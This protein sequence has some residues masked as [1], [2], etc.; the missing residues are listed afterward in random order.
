M[1]ISIQTLVPRAVAL[2]AIGYCAWPSV[3]ALMEEPENKPVVQ[4]P[5]LDGSLLKPKMPPRPVRNPFAVKLPDL[6]PSQH[7]A[8]A[9]AARG[10][11]GKTAGAAAN[12]AR[13][14]TDAAVQPPPPINPLA[15]LKLEATCIAGDRRI[16]VVN[17]RQYSVQDLLR[18]ASPAGPPL[19]IVNVLPHQI[20]LQY[21]GKTLALRYTGAV[22]PAPSPTANAGAKRFN[23]DSGA[24]RQSATTADAPAKSDAADN[25][26]DS[27]R[28]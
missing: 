11:T 27:P 23:R 22:R 16:A 7:S 4:M 21:E 28:K 2:A 14:K 3:S 10:K 12:A 18:S 9:A 1:T 15:G 8:S 25:R 6:P 24:N 20:L 26:N 17:G 19:K 5:A 13:Q